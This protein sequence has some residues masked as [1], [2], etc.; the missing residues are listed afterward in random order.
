M[1][2]KNISLDNKNQISG[3]KPRVV[4]TF[5]EAGMAHIMAMTGMMDAFQ[6]KYGDKC[7]CIKSYIFSDSKNQD[8]KKM[9]ETVSGHT[10]KTA[11]N[12]LYNRFEA[13]SYLTSSR[14][15]LK[16]L[17][18]HFRKGRKGFLQDAKELNPDLLVASYYLP[19]HLVVETNKKGITDTLIATYTPDPYIYPAW[20]RR[21]DLFLVNNERA[22]ELAVKKGFKKEVVRQIP[23]IYKEELLHFNATRQQAKK[24]VNIDDK[25][26][27]LFSSGAYGAK[28]T[29]KLVKKLLATSLPM[30]LYVICGK[31]EE[32]KVRLENLKNSMETQVNLQVIGF[33]DKLAYYMKA[34]DLLIGKA[35][36][37]TM[38]EARYLECP[39]IANV[40]A[41]RLEEIIA[42][43]AE[44]YGL[45]KKEYR[46][47]GV[48]KL[49]EKCFNDRDYLSSRLINIKDREGE[50]LGCEKAADLLYDLLKK[51][52][53][54]LD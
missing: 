13:L 20:D 34:S 45:A 1:T 4:F 5:V 14:L 16:F 32:I 37:L 17:D 23:F 27:V 49:V 54:D 42:N 21:C 41:N 44:K 51:K 46:A 30:N 26:T 53:P 38:M 43:Y 15:T 36:F 6:K 40:A 50:M 39:M 47:N 29:E 35:G 52:F 19:S 12:W 31:N 33:T 10:K 11:S 48:V 18:G 3:R 28:G 7:E 22:Y 8:V 9:G 2:E 25:F 24:E